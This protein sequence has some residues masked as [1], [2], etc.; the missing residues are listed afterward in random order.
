LLFPQEIIEQKRG[1]KMAIK[2]GENKKP[3]LMLN[4]DAI[5]PL[6]HRPHAPSCHNFKSPGGYSVSYWSKL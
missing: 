3:G 6:S 1:R 5:I 2:M 4:Y